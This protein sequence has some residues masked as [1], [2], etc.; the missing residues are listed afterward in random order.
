MT[1]N[2]E[3]AQAQPGPNIV[4][5]SLQHLGARFPSKE[6]VAK[7]HEVLEIRKTGLPLGGI[8]GR[9]ARKG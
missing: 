8:E 6:C 5:K 1:H 7:T 9:A 3:T 2:T 4:L